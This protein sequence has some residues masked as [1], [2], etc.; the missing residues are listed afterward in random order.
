MTIFNPD[1]FMFGKGE[2]NFGG[3][4]ITDD[5]VKPTSAMIDAIAN[6][7]TPTDITGICSWFGLVNQVAYSFAQADIM[8]LFCKFLSS[9]NKKFY[10]VSSLDQIFDK[11]KWKIVDLIIESVKSFEVD[12]PTCIPSDW[13]KTRIGFILCQQHC[14]CPTTQGPV[15]GE[16]HWKLVFA[17]SVVKHLH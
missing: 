15:R 17:G 5:G 16:G 9:K 11:S 13:S 2:V 6:F 4:T 1:K 8:S 7:P 12:K 10:W 14:N 3:F